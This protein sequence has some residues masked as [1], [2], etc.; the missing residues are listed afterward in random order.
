MKYEE[1]MKSQ[2]A[3]GWKLAVDDEH[4]RMVRTPVPK[5]D[6]ANDAKILSSTWTMKKKSN[7]TLR[8]RLNG[9]GFEQV[10]RIHYDPKSIAAL[11]IR[12][13]FVSMVMA[14]WTGHVLN[15]RGAFLKGSFGHKE[16]LYLHVP[17]RMEKWYTGDVVLLLHKTLYGL[18]QA[19]Y[20]FWL[21]LLTIVRCLRFTRSK[22]DPCLY[23]KWRDTGGLLLWF[24][25][26]DDCFLTGPTDVLWLAKEHI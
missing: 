5:S 13:V 7:G 4:K 10:P 24:T 22:A 2:D 12:I 19:A 6:V 16:T 15:V 18:K 17:Q 20:R 25:W 23:Y 21:F 3:E 9:R 8:A 11:T 26:V 14:G 1:A